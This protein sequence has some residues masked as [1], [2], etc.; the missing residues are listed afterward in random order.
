MRSLTALLRPLALV[1]A[2]LVFSLPAVAA[3]LVMIDRQGCAYCIAWKKEIG[4]AYPNTDLGQ[5]APLRV[6]DIRDG[7]PEG[8]TFARPV[9]FTPTFILIED[10]AELARLEGYAGEDFFW[11]LLEKMLKENTDFVGSS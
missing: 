6:V 7:A 3:E 2:G 1:A 5:F 8:V 11:G 9:V 10:G 4:P